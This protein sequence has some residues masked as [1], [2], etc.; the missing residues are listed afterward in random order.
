MKFSER[1]GYSLVRKIQI[2]SMDDELRIS[3]WNKIQNYF[4]KN[5][6]IPGFRSRSGGNNFYTI[7]RNEIWGQHFKEVVD[8]LN[9]AHLRAQFRKIY[10]EN[11]EWYKVYDLIEF[12]VKKFPPNIS[13][14]DKNYKK[15]KFIENCNSV[16]KRENSAYRFINEKITPITSEIEIQEIEEALKVYDYFK[17]VSIHINDALK[18]LSDRKEPNYRNSVKESISAV[19]S[20]CQIITQNKNVTLGKALKRIEDHIK[21]H[22]ALKNAFSQLYGYTS[23]EGGIRHAL[24]D[25]SNIDFEDAKFML[26]SCSAF[27][28]YLKVK[29]SK[30]NLKFK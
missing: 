11:L 16:L 20:I 5:I 13:L 22:G 1:Y 9:P 26:I 3:L 10:F 15:N 19:E 12:I 28:N 30:A 17:P 24:L 4:L 2:K 8:D 7:F 29:I 6:A 27:I 18:F 23:S 25:E 14:T 21:I